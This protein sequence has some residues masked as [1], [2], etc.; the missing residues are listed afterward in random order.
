MKDIFNAE[1]VTVQIDERGS[2]I[3]VCVNGETVLRCARI[4]ELEIKDFRLAREEDD[5]KSDERRQERPSK[6][7]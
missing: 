3:W 5:D 2:R 6:S 1:Y 4:K 7:S